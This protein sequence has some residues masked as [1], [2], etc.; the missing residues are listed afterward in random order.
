M[1][2]TCIQWDT[3]GNKELLKEFPTEMKLPEKLTDGEIEIW[4]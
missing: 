3:D 1:K 2:A 4:E